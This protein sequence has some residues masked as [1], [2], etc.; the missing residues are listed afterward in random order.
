MSKPDQAGSVRDPGDEGGRLPLIA[1][2]ALDPVQ[3]TLRERLLQSRS[4]AEGA[5]YD[6][7]L[8]D[9]RLIGPFNAALR[10]PAI[11][12]GLFAWGQAIAAA[13]LPADVREVVILT[14]AGRWRSE[15]ML[16]AH[17]A[18]A[19]RLGVGDSAIALLRDGQSPPNLGAGAE[20]AHRLTCALIDD[21]HVP[22]H[23]Y[24][25]AVESFGV[26][27]LVAL[28]N[29]IGQYQNTAAILA[30]FDVPAPRSA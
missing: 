29:L 21:H 14:I 4:G 17:E 3:Q 9:G 2:E 15:Y 25:D 30:C 5:D 24:D 13:G 22:Q 28:I 8:A 16:Y 20:L 11:A 6:V 27:A 18:V 7:A 10:A 12:G 26:E 23:L 1:V 19:R